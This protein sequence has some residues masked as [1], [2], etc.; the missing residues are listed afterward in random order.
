MHG[1]SVC[2]VLFTDFGVYT[3]ILQQTILATRLDKGKI[4]LPIFWISAE[5]V[6][7]KVTWAFVKFCP[8]WGAFGVL[9]CTGKDTT[10]IG[11]NFH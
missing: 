1:R 7:Y 5:A 6:L 9:A 3:I 8:C 10:A 2:D 11:V 4:P